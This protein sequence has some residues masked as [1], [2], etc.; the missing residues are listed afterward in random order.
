MKIPNK[1][2]GAV[3]PR[4]ISARRVKRRYGVW[5]RSISTSTNSTGVIIRLSKREKWHDTLETLVASRQNSCLWVE[6]GFS[7]TRRAFLPKGQTAVA[8]Q[9]QINV[10][11]DN[12]AL[13]AICEEFNLAS[14][15][16]GP[17]AMGLL[18]GKFSAGAT[19]PIDDVRGRHSPEWMGYFK[20]AKPTRSG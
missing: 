18:T 7:R 10:L 17:L 9:H 12:P 1:S 11:D 14:I 2:R 5:T 15:N 13:V 19:L 6:H 16:R 20:M 8:I 4:T 3:R